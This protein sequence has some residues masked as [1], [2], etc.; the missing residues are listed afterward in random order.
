MRKNE[1]LNDIITCRYLLTVGN[2]REATV[3]TPYREFRPGIM[4]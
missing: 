1:Y 4:V 2:L 3:H